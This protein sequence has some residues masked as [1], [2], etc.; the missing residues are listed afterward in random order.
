M[1]ALAR[2]ALREIAAKLQPVRGELGGVPLFLSMPEPRWGFS[3][4]DADAIAGALVDG[5][6]LDSWS[7]DV[8]PV[9]EGHAGGLR[10]MQLARERLLA[11]SAGLCLVGGVDSY[12][13]SETLRW[14]ESERR[15]SRTGVR[16]G[17]APGE[18]AVMIALTAGRRSLG[19]RLP[20]LAYVREVGYAQE[21]R[22]LD[23]QEGTLGEGLTAAVR[24]IARAMRPGEQ[25]S[26]VY[27]DINGE[28]HRTE[29][30]GF[31]LLRLP[32]LFRD[33]SQFLTTVP[34]CG[35]LGAASALLHVVLAARSWQRGYAKGPRAL[36]WAGSWGGSRGAVLLEQVELGS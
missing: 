20:A 11:G 33:G 3:H 1:T 23:S 7:I 5:V 24:S 2:F 32:Q 31:T 26:D 17:F 16:T 18:G 9:L 22:A 36:V 29:D 35:D 10:A 30:W 13:H 25:V 21:P 15:L 28:R 34:Q 8:R 6:E 27:G 14:L 12:L 4:A 19:S